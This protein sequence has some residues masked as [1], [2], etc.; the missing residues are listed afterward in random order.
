MSHIDQNCLEE[1]TTNSYA[2]APTRIK[3]VSKCEQETVD[4]SRPQIPP[5]STSELPD[6]LTT[7]RCAL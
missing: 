5:I 2:K 6:W 4:H 1:Y 7:K 3:T